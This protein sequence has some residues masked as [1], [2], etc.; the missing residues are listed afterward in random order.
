VKVDN[1]NNY[2]YLVVVNDD[3][4][5]LV[6]L[7]REILGDEKQH[8]ESKGQIAFNC[9]M[10]DEGRNKGNL[11]INYHDH[12]FKCWC[13]SDIN[14][15]KGSLNKFFNKFGNKKQKKIYT[16][17]HPETN[18]PIEKKIPK[19]KLPESFIM[20]K[21]SNPVYPIRRQAMNYLKQRGI[22]DE[23]IEKYN[24]GFCDKGS[25]KGRI[26]IP[27]YNLKGE[28]NYYVARS[29][30]PNTKS[31]YKNPEA[32]KDKIIFNENLID[33][34]KDV[35][36]VEGV[37]DAFFLENSIP[38]LGKHLSEMLFNTLYN[39]VKSNIIIALDGDAYEN[40][41]KIYHEL[42]GGDLYGRVK[43]IKLPQDKDVCDLKGRI[44]EYYVTIR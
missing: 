6:E 12:V 9:I 33:W 40:G 42:N 11:E 34:N 30:D 29:W 10:C 17:L 21:D 16:I 25:H 13:C 20:F 31:K 39:N 38:M 26:V 18:K 5:I 43:L 19:L 36:L 3:K 22:T 2:S 7:L 23:I 4:E 27:S 8:Y 37:F 35:Y 44:G 15:T 32:E 28:L 24:I 1:Y 41:L 14:D